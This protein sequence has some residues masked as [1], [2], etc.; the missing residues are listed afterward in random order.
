MKID[1]VGS[2]VIKVQDARITPAVKK[3]DN[4]DKVNKINKV[5]KDDNE[6]RTDTDEDK[7]INDNVLE[8]SVK[9]A[10]KSLEQFNRM[11]EITI[12]EKTH[13]IIYVIKDTLTNEV[14][15]EFPPR[16]IQDMI[17]KMWEMAGILIDE[18][19]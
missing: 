3:S 1:N 16:K 18:R 17:A 11:I 9:Q 12:H 5:N 4:E 13:T 7:A 6:K 8:N 10:N 14:I 15:K 2:S 19:R